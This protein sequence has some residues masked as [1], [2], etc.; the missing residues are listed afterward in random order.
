M[1]QISVPV[2]L[3]GAGNS[4]ATMKR[5]KGFTLTNHYQKGGPE[6][7]SLFQTSARLFRPTYAHQPRQLI[8]GEDIEMHNKPQTLNKVCRDKRHP[9]F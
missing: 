9:N 2:S 3:L 6:K 8:T 7:F 1:T 4:P 5:K